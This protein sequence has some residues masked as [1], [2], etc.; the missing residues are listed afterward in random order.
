[1]AAMDIADIRTLFRAIAD[2]LI[3]GGIF[4]FSIH[5]PC[6]LK[7]EGVYLTPAVHEGEA[8]WGQPVM[9]L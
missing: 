4:V 7:P 6:F 2:L 1:M 3:H 8:I 5:P 9:Q